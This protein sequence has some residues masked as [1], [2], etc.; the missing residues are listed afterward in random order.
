VRDLGFE[1]RVRLPEGL[2][3]TARWYEE[4]GYLR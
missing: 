2:R 1:A 3:R 4:R